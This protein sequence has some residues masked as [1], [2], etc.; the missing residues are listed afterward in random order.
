M[1][2]QIAFTEKDKNRADANYSKG[3]MRRRRSVSFDK[4]V[5]VV[6][7]PHVSDFTED[8]LDLLWFT[9]EEYEQTRK[10]CMK[11][12]RSMN[13]IRNEADDTNS[14]ESQDCSRRSLLDSCTRGLE[15]LSKAR[16]TTRRIR[17]LA[18]ADAILTEQN[19]QREEGRS[20]AE[21][22]R[23]LYEKISLCCQEEAKKVALRD[24]EEA[25]QYYKS[26]ESSSRA[27]RLATKKKTSRLATT[28][29]PLGRIESSIS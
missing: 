21:F 2:E 7:I 28:Y 24:Q 16:A 4:A 9:E 23:R 17:R 6:T 12:V 8:E 29:S 11:I 13:K 22:L 1:K 19:F 18:A 5:K 25:L 3:K 20:D 15:S 27:I 14:I 26:P 10:N